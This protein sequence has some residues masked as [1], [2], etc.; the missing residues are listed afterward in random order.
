MGKCTA[1]YPGPFIVPNAE[2]E[3]DSEV[4]DL[5]KFDPNPTSFHIGMNFSTR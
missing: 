2:A 4:S 5:C 1:N 3:V